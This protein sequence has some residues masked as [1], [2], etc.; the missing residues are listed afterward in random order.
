MNKV[1]QV[2]VRAIA[3][4]HGQCTWTTEADA[5]YFGVYEGEPGAFAWLADFADKDDALNW[6][7]AR[8]MRL[9]ATLHNRIGE[10]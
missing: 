4:D 9:G 6:A 7:N 1:K 5:N 3:D 2:E 8:A 10:V